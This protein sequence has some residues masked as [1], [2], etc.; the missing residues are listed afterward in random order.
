M[1]IELAGQTVGVTISIGVAMSRDSS[2]TADALLRAADIAMY[3]AKNEG[4]NRV[5]AAPSMPA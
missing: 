5:I 4:R 1:C 3:V 2:E